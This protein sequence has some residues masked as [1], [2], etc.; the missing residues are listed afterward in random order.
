MS[1]AVYMLAI[2]GGGIIWERAQGSPWELE[3][4]PTAGGGLTQ[5][6]T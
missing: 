1:I 3:R 2:F 5:V 6:S 4:F